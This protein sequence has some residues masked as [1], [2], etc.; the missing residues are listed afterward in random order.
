MSY[1]PVLPDGCYVSTGGEAEWKRGGKRK[2]E[3]EEMEE[4]NE[5]TDARTCC[6]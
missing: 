5:A 6:S 3:M 1:L 4:K 2:K